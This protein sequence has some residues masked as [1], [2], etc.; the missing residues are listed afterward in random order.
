M[1]QLLEDL[2]T[3]AADSIRT[4]FGTRRRDPNGEE[5]PVYREEHEQYRADG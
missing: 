2:H 3:V 4:Y 5:P 1:D